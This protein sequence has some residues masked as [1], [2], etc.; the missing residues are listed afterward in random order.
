MP[1]KSKEHNCGSMD[2]R[3]R[4]CG[5]AFFFGERITGSTKAIPK[6]GRQCCAEGGVNLD[7]LPAL[8]DD[9]AKLFASDADFK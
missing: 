6:F 3:C 4:H 8:P 9:L 7:P 2:Q 1:L 5:A